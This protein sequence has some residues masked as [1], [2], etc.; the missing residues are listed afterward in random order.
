MFFTIQNPSHLIRIYI[1]IMYSI[2]NYFY[3][4]LHAMDIK[5]YQIVSDCDLVRSGHH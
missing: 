5:M 1:F 2:V 4:N 3:L